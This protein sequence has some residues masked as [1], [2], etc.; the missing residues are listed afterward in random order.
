MAQA[1]YKNNFRRRSER[2][3]NDGLTHNRQIM[4]DDVYGSLFFAKKGKIVFDS[5][6][7]RKLLAQGLPC[8][9]TDTRFGNFDTCYFAGKRK[10]TIIRNMNKFTSLYKIN[11]PILFQNKYV[12]FKGLQY[13][14][15]PNTCDVVFKNDM[16]IDVNILKDEWLKNIASDFL[17]N[18]FTVLHKPNNQYVYNDE[19]DYKKGYK[20][21]KSDAIIAYGHGKRIG[22]SSKGE[23]L[24]GYSCGSE[25]ILVEYDIN[26]DKWSKCW[27]VSKEKSNSDIIKEIIKLED[28]EPSYY[29]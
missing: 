3:M 23:D 2:V 4:F 13:T 10:K 18:G 14:V 27:E 9:Y 7:Q 12:R 11:V 19:N 8:I 24:F 5:F 26:F 1:K 21:I 22:V 28:E 25:N 20:T 29:I 6:E 17:N 15:K 16:N